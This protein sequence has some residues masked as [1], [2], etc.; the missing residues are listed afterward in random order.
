MKKEIKAIRKLQGKTTKEAMDASAVYYSHRRTVVREEEEVV[1]SIKRNGEFEVMEDGIKLFASAFKS[2]LK[3]MIREVITEILADIAQEMTP[4]IKDMVTE[5]VQETVHQDIIDEMVEYHEKVTE[6]ESK[7]ND[8]SYVLPSGRI[9]WKH[10]IYS[11]HEILFKEL[12][13]LVQE[14]ININKAGEVMKASSAVYQKGL[15]L[16][17]K[18]W[19]RVVE[20]Y[21]KQV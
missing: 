4:A 9:Q 18:E 2:V 8:Y 15:K 12:D 5:V 7:D 13:R 3:P 1:M 19:T 20:A 14:G 21:I 6:H 11:E 16:Y 17:H 10:P